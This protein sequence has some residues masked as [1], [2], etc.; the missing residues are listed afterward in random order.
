MGG[1]EEQVKVS[2]RGMGS[3]YSFFITYRF[4]REHP[5]TGPTRRPPACLY[6]YSRQNLVPA[7]PTMKISQSLNVPTFP[8]RQ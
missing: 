3:E 6:E 7:P 1:K 8:V 2:E 4:T 5:A